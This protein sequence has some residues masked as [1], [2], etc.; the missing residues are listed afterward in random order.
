[1]LP[2]LGPTRK[3]AEGVEEATA[4]LGK[5]QGVVMVGTV[6]DIGNSRRALLLRSERELEAH[7]CEEAGN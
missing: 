2:P 4:V 1:M 6:R 5:T 7:T 3:G